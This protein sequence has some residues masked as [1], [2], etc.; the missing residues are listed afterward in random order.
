MKTGEEEQN[1]DVKR[2]LHADRL[3]YLGAIRLRSTMPKNPNAW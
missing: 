2:L 3:I 1:I